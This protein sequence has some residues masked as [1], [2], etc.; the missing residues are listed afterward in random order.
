MSIT[1]EEVFSGQKRKKREEE[2][3]KLEFG[4]KGYLNDPMFRGIACATGG[5]AIGAS[6]GY[7][8][9]GASGAFKGAAIGGGISF[10]MWLLAEIAFGNKRKGG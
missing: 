6:L 3:V 1:Y 2:L 10:L 9:E 4:A 5:S 8:A 7:I